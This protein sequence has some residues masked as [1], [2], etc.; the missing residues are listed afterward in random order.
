MA[1]AKR[2][3]FFPYATA[4]GP[5]LTPHLWCR[6]I[7]HRN[8]RWAHQEARQTLR[9]GAKRLAPPKNR[10]GPG[11]ATGEGGVASV[12]VEYVG[13]GGLSAANC[14]QLVER[15]SN[16]NWFV[17]RGLAAVRPER[18]SVRGRED[19]FLCNTYSHSSTQ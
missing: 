2:G 8:A 18:L 15:V 1:I 19:S 5:C 10:Q 16:F 4:Q 11:S 9:C 17:L 14:L 3:T 13:R 7:R 12:P 6:E